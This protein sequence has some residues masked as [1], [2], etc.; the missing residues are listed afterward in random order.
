MALVR[1]PI[2]EGAPTALI[3]SFR[4]VYGYLRKL[5]MD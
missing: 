3:A 5:N 4:I 2:V 1:K